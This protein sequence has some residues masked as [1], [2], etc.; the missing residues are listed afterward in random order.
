[1]VMSVQS[2]FDVSAPFSRPQK[3]DNFCTDKISEQLESPVMTH[4]MSSGWTLPERLCL[5]LVRTE[6]NL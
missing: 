5:W 1:M 3:Q 6:E 4:G 2:G